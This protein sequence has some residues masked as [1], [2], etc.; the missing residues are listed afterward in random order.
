LLSSDL[1]VNVSA[2]SSRRDLVDEIQARYPNEETGRIR[3]QSA[4]FFATVHSPGEFYEVCKVIE[5]KFG[6][7]VEIG[8]GD[9]AVKGSVSLR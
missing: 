8:R 2:R 9:R 5:P 1:T 3:A 4:T 7:N 6:N